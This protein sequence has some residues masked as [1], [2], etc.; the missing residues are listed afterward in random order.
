MLDRLETKEDWDSLSEEEW[1][2]L[3]WQEDFSDEEIEALF[4]EL[5]EW[6]FE[7]DPETTWPLNIAGEYE[8]LLY[9]GDEKNNWHYV[10]ITEQGPGSFLWTNRADVSW[11][12]TQHM[13]NSTLFA[14]GEECPYYDWNDRNEA[15]F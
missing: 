2:Y 8:C 4:D 13:P 11:T 9:S 5:D 15:N 1:S 7:K 14:V 10:T 12:L 3:I 6:R